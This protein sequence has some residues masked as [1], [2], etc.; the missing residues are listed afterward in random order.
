[1]TAHQIVDRYTTTIRPFS[2]ASRA[3]YR[4]ESWDHDTFMIASMLT[5]LFALL[6]AMGVLFSKPA[7]P[8]AVFTGAMALSGVAA[9][10]LSVRAARHRR[11]N[12]LVAKQH[13]AEIRPVVLS[14]TGV[15]L[16]DSFG[17]VLIGS[18]TTV[19]RWLFQ[20]V[21]LSVDRDGALVLEVQRNVAAGE[22][23]AQRP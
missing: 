1:M 6:L 10:L 15:T 3:R 12:A 19:R 8:L 11:A 13:L 23:Q 21:E 2:K 7:L 18:R 22:G 20:D 5:A 9:Y 14:Q 4:D 16:P 17:E